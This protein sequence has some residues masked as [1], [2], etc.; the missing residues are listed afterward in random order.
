VRKAFLATATGLV[1]AGVTG[2]AVAQTPN[3]GT[4]DYSSGFGFLEAQRASVGYELIGK[5]PGG[6][7]TSPAQ[8]QFDFRRATNG[9][10]FHAV[11]VCIRADGNRAVLG[12]RV[13]S[14]T[15]P[16]YLR[17]QFVEALAVDNVKGNG[18]PHRGDQFDLDD[19]SGTSAPDCQEQA[20]Q[21]QLSTIR[22]DIVV[23]DGG[24]AGQ[25]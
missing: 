1:V 17:G 10:G 5:V 18:G 21:F 23:K 14:S 20:N 9:R 24:F 12:L 13:T 8:G 25:T 19:R 3:A 2:A 11:A 15:D 22:G 16:N 4:S 7:G 6:V